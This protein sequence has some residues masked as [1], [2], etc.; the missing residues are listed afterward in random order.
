MSDLETNQT[1]MLRALQAL[2]A[3]IAALKS[4]DSTQAVNADLKAQVAALEGRIQTLTSASEETLKDL[5]LA[6]GQLAQL[7]DLQAAGGAD[8]G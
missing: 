8:H 7:G 4:G 5:D 2:E 6:L 1:R 3:R